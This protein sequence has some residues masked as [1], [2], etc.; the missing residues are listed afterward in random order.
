MTWYDV[1]VFENGWE[2]LEGLMYAIPV[3]AV[4]RGAI[5]AL[6]KKTTYED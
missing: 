5:W 6:V 1:I 4:L 3:T 2:M